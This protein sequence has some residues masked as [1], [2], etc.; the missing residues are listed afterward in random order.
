MDDG[1]VHAGIGVGFFFE[2]GGR[3]EELLPEV[4]SA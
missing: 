3:L 4:R 2:T 1:K